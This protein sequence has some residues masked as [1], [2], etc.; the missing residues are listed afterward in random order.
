MSVYLR[1]R[2][3]SL[4][5]CLSNFVSVFV[6]CADSDEERKRKKKKRKLSKKTSTLHGSLEV[7]A[8]CC[9]YSIYKTA[10]C[11]SRRLYAVLGLS[12]K[13]PHLHCIK[14]LSSSAH[15]HVVCSIFA[16]LFHFLRASVC[17]I[18][19]TVPILVSSTSPLRLLCS[20]VRAA[21]LLPYVACLRCPRRLGQCQAQGERATGEEEEVE[22]RGG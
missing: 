13:S 4:A 22:A 20:C 11:T 3:R 18:S 7:V 21:F 12:I 2:S 14:G 19:C 15:V 9:L 8:F 6:S 16:L 10:R 5:L 17:V 1:F